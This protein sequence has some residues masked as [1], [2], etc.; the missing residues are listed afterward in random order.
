[1]VL[2]KKRSAGSV[3]VYTID[4][5]AKAGDDFEKVDE[6]VTFNKGETHKFITV[7]INDDDNWEPDEDFFVQLYDVNAR[8]DLIG[9]DTRTRVTIIDDDKP[10]QIGFK[11][12]KAIAALASEEVANIVIERKNGSDGVVT[13]DFTTIELDDS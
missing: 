7:I 11:E 12:Q 1:M 13:V 6:V 5:E 2:N 9:Q 4:A 3:R 8:E 10:G